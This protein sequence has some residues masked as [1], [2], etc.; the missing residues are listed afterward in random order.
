MWEVVGYYF[1]GKQS[2]TI[3]ENDSGKTKKIKGVI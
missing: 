1:D 3:Y 2:W